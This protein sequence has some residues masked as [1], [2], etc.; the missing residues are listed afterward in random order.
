MKDAE[1]FK[2]D[3]SSMIYKE[4]QEEPQQPQ[5]LLIDPSNKV[6]QLAKQMGCI[7][8]SGLRLHKQG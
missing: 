6:Y 7:R 5:P 2:E 3:F 4:D 1:I 8:T